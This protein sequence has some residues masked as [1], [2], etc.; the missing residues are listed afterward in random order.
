MAQE[1][2]DDA[3]TLP[4]FDVVVWED[5]Q[6]L[7]VRGLANQKIADARNDLVVRTIA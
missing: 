2:P 1:S 6:R 3:R 7:F 4:Q 5:E